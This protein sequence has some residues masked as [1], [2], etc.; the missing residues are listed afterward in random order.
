MHLK[1]LLERGL[2]IKAY[3]ECETITEIEIARS[4]RQEIH[5]L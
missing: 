4:D 5:T 2:I 3:K 1:N